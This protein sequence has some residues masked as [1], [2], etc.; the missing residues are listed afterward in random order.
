MTASIRKFGDAIDTDVI[1]PGRYLTSRD[2][3]FLGSHCM[4]GADPT[5]ANR[6]KRGDVVVAGKNFGCG[7]SREHAVLALQGAG[8]ACV[9]AASFAR[10][11]FRNAINNGL[12]VLVCPEAAVIAHDGEPILI[13]TESGIINL[14]GRSFRSEPFPEFIQA[15][16]SSGGIVPF[17]RMRLQ[18][19]RE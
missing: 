1:I 4:E 12:S 3:A 14:D 9:V 15:I 8:I 19:K 2:P 16:V 18:T 13:D 5:F 17:V 11:F 10:I 7:S 6:V